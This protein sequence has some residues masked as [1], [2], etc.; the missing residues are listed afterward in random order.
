MNLKKM[1]PI[2]ILGAMLLMN[3]CGGGSTSSNNASKTQEN[4]IASAKKVLQELRT[5]AISIVDYNNSAEPG[6]L[7]SE[8]L[9]INNALGECSQNSLKL[10]S[11]IIKYLENDDNVTNESW[12]DGS[13]F[14]R[15]CN[16]QGNIITCSYEHKKDN[17]TYSGNYQFNKFKSPD[18]L[19]I[20]ESLHYEF[21]GTVPINDYKTRQTYDL[22]STITKTGNGIEYLL[23]NTSI[24]NNNTKLGISDLNVTKI[25]DDNGAHHLELNTISLN[26]QCKN[27]KTEGVFNLQNYVENDNQLGWFPKNIN[28]SG[29]LKNNATQ[30]EISASV[31][32]SLEN[33]KT[34]TEYDDK[35]VNIS[36]NGTLQMPER[37]KLTIALSYKNSIDELD[38]YHNYGAK[39]SYDDTHINIDSIMDKE[40]KNGEITI[41]SKVGITFKV[42]I[43]DGKL[44]EGDGDNETGSIV[45]YNGELIGTLEY[46]NKVVIV[47]YSDG[48][49]ESIP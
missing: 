40:N 3:G 42:I 44:V 47:K 4:K 31:D 36:V 43:L 11:K 2:S 17:N 15:E 19:E 33:I 26:G 30:G 18:E 9:K 46:R 16:K 35:A 41:N 14:S 25:N 28:F 27:Y 49:F 7:D 22:N 6:Y 29:S 13:V 38:K 8:A 48:T 23:K 32:V 1:L 12:D 20:G 34:I 24:E 21:H 5:E 39:Y 45:T 10:S 37:P